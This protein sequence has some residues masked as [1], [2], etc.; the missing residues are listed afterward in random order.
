[1]S[2]AEAPLRGARA[3]AAVLE[4]GEAICLLAFARSINPQALPERASQERLMLHSVGSVT[5]LIGLVSLSDYCGA[6]AERNLAD[7]AW[8]APRVRRHADLVNWTMRRS[9]VFPVPFATLY[10]TFDSLTDFMRAHEQAISAFLQGVDGK[11]EWDL[12]AGADLDDPEMLDRLACEAWPDWRA[13]PKGARYMRLCRDREALLEYGRAAAAALVN[14]FVAEIEPLTAAVRLQDPGRR[15]ESG[16]GEPVARYALLVHK[17]N[18]A[19]I[20][21]RVGEIAAEASLRHVAIGLSGPWP[22]F[23]FRPDLSTP[24]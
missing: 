5:A 3:G 10:K 15:V 1:M 17:A 2:K 24:N 21:A 7:V 4:S 22:P 6:D 8:I 11:E 20:R 19:E 14:G 13:L 16:R 23:S 9:P 18:A 12:R